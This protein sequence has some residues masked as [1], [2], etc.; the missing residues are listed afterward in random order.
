MS[1]EKTLWLAAISALN[2]LEL[3]EHRDG[4]WVRLRPP[5]VLVIDTPYGLEPLESTLVP[6][7]KRTV[8]VGKQE[9]VRTDDHGRGLIG[10]GD[11]DVKVP[12]QR[13]LPLTST[14]YVGDSVESPPREVDF[15][16]NPELFRRF[17]GFLV[18][19]WVVA[20]PVRPAGKD[21]QKQAAKFRQ[22]ARDYDPG[23]IA[24][25]WR[26]MEHTWPFSDGRPWDAFD[27][28]KHFNK[29]R[30]NAATIAPVTTPEGWD[31]WLA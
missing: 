29:A 26:G 7:E 14:T 10:G 25:A 9:L 13:H 11:G 15:Q 31:E 27:L 19:I 21:I 16:S 1:E 6:V 22:V 28:E 2:R 24:E 12:D 8:A 18:G 3:L 30:Q 23:M 17:V 5:A 4:G 20:Q